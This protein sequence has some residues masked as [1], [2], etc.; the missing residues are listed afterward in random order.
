M[1]TNIVLF[2]FDGTIVDSAPIIMQA[3]VDTLDE[4]GL[5]PQ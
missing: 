5:P 4:L 1:N 3:V 2:D